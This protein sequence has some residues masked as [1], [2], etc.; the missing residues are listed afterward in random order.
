MK[1]TYV[2]MTL[3]SHTEAAHEMPQNCEMRTVN[4]W[5]GMSNSYFWHSLAVYLEQLGTDSH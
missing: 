1:T 5:H 3:A 2:V 4:F